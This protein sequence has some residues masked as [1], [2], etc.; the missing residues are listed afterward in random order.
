M[1]FFLYFFFK[2][3]VC[4]HPSL[5]FGPLRDERVSSVLS[6]QQ[7]HKYLLSIRECRVVWRR[8]TLTVC[9]VINHQDRGEGKRCRGGFSFHSSFF[10][11]FLTRMLV[12]WSSNQLGATKSPRH[13]KITRNLAW[14]SY[15]L[16]LRGF[17]L[18]QSKPCAWTS[19]KNHCLLC[20]ACS[21]NTFTIQHTL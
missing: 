20:N 10:F 3:I 15:G 16:Q 5:R 2:N 8:Q 14:W 19:Y 13:I 21:Y 11:F 6:A 17:V 18:P 9:G 12:V 4:L 1:Y 7:T